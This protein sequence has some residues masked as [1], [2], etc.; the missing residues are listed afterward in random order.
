VANSY[1]LRCSEQRDGQQRSVLQ[2][3]QEGWGPEGADPA[4]MPLYEDVEA[5]AHEFLTGHGVPLPLVAIG[6][7]PLGC[8]EDRTLPLGQA[9]WLAPGEAGVERRDGE[10]A[11]AHFDSQHPP[12]L[13][14][15]VSS[16]FGLMLFEERYVEGPPGEAQVERLL[17]IEEALLARAKQ[18]RPD[19]D[20]SLTVSYHAGVHQERMDALLRARQRHTLPREHRMER[21][22]WWQFWR[23]FGRVR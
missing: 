5:R 17:Q 10:L 13:P 8:P 3:P 15:H 21:P 9:C 16:D 12:V 18:A 19:A 23:Y 14:T 2:M 22:P 20:V 1:R 6:A 7:A 4:Q 11:V